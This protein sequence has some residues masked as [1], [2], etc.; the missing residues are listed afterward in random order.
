MAALPPDAV[1]AF[2]DAVQW[3]VEQSVFRRALGG[4]RAVLA[5]M[6]TASLDDLIGAVA[7]DPRCGWFDREFSQTQHFNVWWYDRADA[8][9]LCL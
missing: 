5:D 2:V 9:P 3:L 7:T 1:D 4:L 8:V 6:P